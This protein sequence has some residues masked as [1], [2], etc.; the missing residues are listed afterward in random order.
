MTREWPV[1]ALSAGAAVGRL[2]IRR[3]D[4]PHI[5]HRR[6]RRD[7]AQAEVQRFDDALNK[8]RAELESLRRGAREKP[9]AAEV[10]GFINLYLSL[11]ADAEIAQAPRRLIREKLMNAE[12]ALQAQAEKIAESFAQIE[13]DYL[14]ERGADISHVAKR[15]LAAMR[16]AA[17]RRKTGGG[18]GKIFA[19]KEVSP[20]DVI[21]LARLGYA[22]FVCENGNASSHTA[23]LA[24]S[25]GLPAAAGARLDEMEEGERVLLDA[26]NE[27]FIAAPRRADV[28][29][30]EKKMRAAARPAAVKK[31]RTPPLR[32]ADGGRVRIFA[33]LDLPEEADGA[34]AAKVDGVGL[35][36]TEFLFLNRDDLPGEDEQFEIY[37]RVAKTLSPAPVVFR[38]LDLGA[39]KMPADERLAKAAAA[40]NPALGLRALRLCLRMPDVFM[41]QIR[42]LLRAA[43]ARGNIS[44]ML[45][46]MS[47]PAE[48]T[49]TRALIARARADL[50]LPAKTKMP[51]GVMIEVPAA[52]FVMEGIASQLE[53]FSVGTND[54]VQYAMVADRAHE[55]VADYCD[56]RHPAVPFLLS[57]IVRRARAARRPVTLC[58]EIAGDPAFIPLILALGIRSLSMNTFCVDE[59]RRA[60][61]AANLSS[62][63]RVRRRLLAART[64][65]ELIGVLDGLSS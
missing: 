51:L 15:I 65:E 19:A 20:T 62:L 40:P 17:A 10:R 46:M 5:P 47:R 32:T 29:A 33:N 52:V 7:R 23:I 25:L 24:R 41:T 50:N 45:P 16:P 6:I 43:A 58:G 14:R 4:D 30:C 8:A 31:T 11:L 53:F 2:E 60:V 63:R 9:F 3:G 61:S 59:V 21:E 49:R 1:R 27:R 28:L 42:A 13:D 37:S 36:R 56:P 54:L 35:F 34:R 39:D 57:E 26:E 44:V 22:A 48:V 38:T 64:P 12:W 55:A 18:R